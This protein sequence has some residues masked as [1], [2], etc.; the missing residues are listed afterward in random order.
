[1]RTGRKKGGR[2]GRGRKGQSEEGV[3]AAQACQQL[4]LGL[5]LGQ[6]PPSASRGD[7]VSYG[8]L[9]SGRNWPRKTHGG[10]EGP[11]PSWVSREK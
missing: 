9:P 11:E 3:S 10:T 7:T 6:C 8:Y 1:M 4:Q 5:S 2:R